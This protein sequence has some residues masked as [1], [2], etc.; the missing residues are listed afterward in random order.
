MSIKAGS[1]EV[2]N[3]AR[4]ADCDHGAGEDDAGVKPAVE[5]CGLSRRFGGHVVLRDVTF[6]V[7][8]GEAVA[9]VGSNGAGK[10]TFLRIAAGVLSQSAGC[11]RVGGA[12][13]KHRG[14]A[15]RA[16]TALLAG[17]S[18]LYDELTAVENLR[19]AVRMSGKKASGRTL[20]HL[21]DTVGLAGVASSR[22]RH[23]SSGMRKR[24]ALAR[25]VAMDPPV[26]LLDEPYASLDEDA[27]R[28]VDDVVEEWREG[29]RAVVM[30]THLKERARRVC[31]RTLH[32]VDGFMLAEVQD[33][34]A[35]GS[36]AGPSPVRLAEVA[37]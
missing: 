14:D 32:L 10:S 37:P 25:V 15:V 36:G 1:R 13:M 4:S 33:I 6:Q 19:F 20:H 29:G 21:L 16:S 28:L 31:D 9:L 27:S 8:W 3:P 2:P 17:D 5:A 22:I 24:L 30:A 35:P 34:V 7:A 12:C 18:F 26:L 23:F 11:V